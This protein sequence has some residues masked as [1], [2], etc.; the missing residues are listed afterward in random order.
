MMAAEDSLLEFQRVHKIVVPEAEE[1]VSQRKGAFLQQEI[2]STQAQMELA[3]ISNSETSSQYQKLAAQVEWLKKQA[4]STENEPFGLEKGRKSEGDAGARLNVWLNYER[5]KR[6]VLIQGTI[7]QVLIQ[8]FEQ[9]Q[10]EARKD[11]SAFTTLDP[12]RVPTKKVAPPTPGK[13]PWC[14]R[15]GCCPTRLA[16]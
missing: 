11:V 15:N 7:V 16:G 3:R 12:V 1:M 2:I 4:N 13:M 6:D 5:I 10:I 8:Q 14:C 9:S